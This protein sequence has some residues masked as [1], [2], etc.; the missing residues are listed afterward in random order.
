MALFH[1]YHSAIIPLLC[2]AGSSLLY[3]TVPKHCLASHV[4]VTEN[5]LRYLASNDRLA[6]LMRIS[7]GGIT[8]QVHFCLLEDFQTPV[9]RRSFHH[10]PCKLS[11]DSDCNGACTDLLEFTRLLDPDGVG[12]NF[13][14]LILRND[15]GFPA[16]PQRQRQTT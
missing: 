5:G 3:N 9:Y 4:N 7:A 11:T 2:G 16:I 14:C 12:G 6:S 15:F 8:P 13:N 1:M 10:R